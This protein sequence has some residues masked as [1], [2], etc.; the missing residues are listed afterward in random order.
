MLRVVLRGILVGQRGSAPGTC[1][2][3]SAGRKFSGVPHPPTA[4]RWGLVL[5]PPLDGATNMAVDAALM[6]RAAARGE[7]VLRVYSWIRPTLSFG[8]NQTALGWYDPRRVPAD[9]D[10]VR[11]P[12]GGRAILHHREVTYSV[13][14]PA[15]SMPG[16][17]QSHARINAILQDALRALGVATDAAGSTGSS[18]RAT[19]ER[20]TSTACF[21]TA[22]PGELL[23][24]GRK[25]VG[26]AQYRDSGALLQHGS[27]LVDDDQQRIALLMTRPIPDAPPAATLHSLLG[28]RPRV[29]EVAEALFG[30]V[31][32]LEDP[33]PAALDPGEVIADAQPYLAHFRDPAWTWRR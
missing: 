32:S 33:E 24:G 31:R 10:V 9:V 8:R 23:S 15:A 14:A 13:T 7:A 29:E 12:T 6:A 1:G 27:I 16:L 28:R 2:C 17:R 22:A 30:A 21:Q 26:S 4:L 3:V 18:G 20:R 5:T 19:A 25:L 11:R